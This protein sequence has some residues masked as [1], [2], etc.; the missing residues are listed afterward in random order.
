MALELDQATP[1]SL[2]HDIVKWIS[3]EYHDM[4]GSSIQT[5]ESPPTAVEF[6]QLVHISRPAIIKGFQIPAL[7]R[8][9]DD[10]LQTNLQGQPV[11]VAITPNGQADA[12]ATGP[13]GKFFFVEPFVEKVS[14]V[15]FLEQLNA[16]Q[17]GDNLPASYLQSQN[18]N[19]YS[20]RFFESPNDDS[21]EFCALRDDVPSNIPWVTEAL[22]RNPDAVNIWIG[23]SK[24]ITSIH[25]DPYENIYTVIRGSKHFTLLPPCEG[26]CLQERM[27]PHAVYGYTDNSNGLSVVPSS[28]TPQVRWSSVINP[29]LPGSLPPE[30]HPLHITLEAG[31][32]LYL[33]VGWWHYVQQSGPTTIALNWWYDAEVRGMNWVW[34]SLLRGS[35]DVPSANDETNTR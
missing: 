34:L 1:P 28:D 17:D 13:G 30:A 12:I 33:P 20:S 21:S 25:S 6:A 15:K 9:T 26:W 22:G 11:S 29:D 7:N 35:G 19:I 31:D 16:E 14:M 2:T 8:W 24:S 3:Q 10:Y 23:N 32:T 5:L 27:Y 4:N 18:G